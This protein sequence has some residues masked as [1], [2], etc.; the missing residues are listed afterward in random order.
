MKLVLSILLLISMIT[1]A[2]YN[3]IEIVCSI[4]FYKRLQREHD[5]F[6]DYLIK[7][8]REKENK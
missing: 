3:I 8:V 5:E 7:S 1:F 6:T 2:I 4:K